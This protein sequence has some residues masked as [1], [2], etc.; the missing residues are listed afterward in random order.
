VT[1][2]VTN[3][4]ATAE[5]IAVADAARLTSLI[6]RASESIDYW[7]GKWFEPRTIQMKVHGRGTS[8]LR[9]PIPIISVE[10]LKHDD[11]E[12]DPEYYYVYNRHL[13]GLTRPDDRVLPCIEMLQALPEEV[14]GSSKFEEGRLNYEVRGRFGYTEY[15]GYVA[16]ELPYDGQTGDFTIGDKVTGATSGATGTIVADDDQG[17]AGTLTLTDVTGEF[18]ENEAIADEHTGAAVSNKTTH[19]E[20]VTPNGIKEAV[21]YMVRRREAKI[22]NPLFDAVFLKGKDAG[23]DMKTGY[24]ITGDPIL[25]EMLLPFMGPAHVGTT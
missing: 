24:E 5:G 23:R 8:K 7:T 12:I 15:D 21:I 17:A 10:W 20:G 19:M 25:D 16:G 13:T 18:V 6:K 14:F 11:Y 2:Y 3:A 22:G 1:A 4:E 9:F